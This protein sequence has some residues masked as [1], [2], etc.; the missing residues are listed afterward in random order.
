MS[1]AQQAEPQGEQLAEQQAE[2]Q[3]LT[4]SVDDPPATAAAPTAA[5]RGKRKTATRPAPKPPLT[6]AADLPVARVAVDVP[7]A[8]LDRPFD[9]LVPESMAETARPGVRVRVR[10]NRQLTDGFL[11]ERVAASD[12]AGKLVPLERVV[13]PEPV[14]GPDLVA[15]AR[16]VADRYAGTLADVLRLAIPPRHART[17]DEPRAEPAPPIDPPTD[18][19]PFAGYRGGP[20]FLAAVAAGGAPRAVWLATPAADT[21]AQDWPAALAVAVRSALAAGRG[22]LVVLPDAR[23]VARLDAAL[24]ERIG[25]GRHVQLTAD[26]GPALRYRRWLAVRRGLV[27]AVIGT[28]AA[29]FA[30]VAELGMLAIWDDGDDLHAEPRA[31]Y[32]HAREV[33]ALRAHQ[34]GAAMLIGGHACTA[35]AAALVRAGW[36]RP[37]VGER[38]VVRARSPLL[39]TVGDDRELAK[40]PAAT[41]ARLP[42]LAWHAARDALKQGPVLVQ[43]PR[44]GY[45]PSLGCERCRAAARCAHCHGPLTLTSGHAMAQCGWCR[46]LAGGWR[47]PLC[48]GDRWRMRVVGAGRTAEELGRAFPDVPVRTSG[49]DAVLDTVDAR[50]ALVVATPGAEP[51]ADDGYAAALLL[52]GWALLN[53]PDLR[54]GEEALRRWL[55]AAALVRPADRG[56][57]VVV[58][59]EP[60]LPPVQALVRWDPAGHAQRELAERDQLGYP[61]AARI[62][63]LVGPESASFDLLGVL[64]EHHLPDGAEVLGP[65]PAAGGDPDGDVRTL[66]RV[67]RRMGAELAAMLRAAQGVRT[68][69]KEPEYVRVRIDP[70]DLG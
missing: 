8:H 26:L 23:D 46:R 66:I 7:L 39:R 65:V 10:F 6:P 19:G 12:Y 17:E 2:Q 68:A 35:E 45:A 20:E 24:T 36:A 37:L 69:R 49:R 42:S 56:G 34:A 63:E 9:Y 21:P 70:A 28:R 60:A 4:P 14:L 55:R 11:L 47:C 41:Q 50:P 44:R 32:P 30:P 38:A 16:T 53:R 59:A 13:S 25:T 64:R 51:V 22:A 15:V 54:A 61:P 3:A 67:P 40:D 5:P 31:P 48:D 33:L 18:P 27:R 52:D 57:V 1:R 29:A 62:A 43:V 58:L